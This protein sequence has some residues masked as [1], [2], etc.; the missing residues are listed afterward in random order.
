MTA[1][2][3]QADREHHE[4]EKE[5]KELGRL[6]ENDKKMKVSLLW[7]SSLQVCYIRTS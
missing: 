5:W 1:L 4:F 6:I 7:R 2:K 3:Q